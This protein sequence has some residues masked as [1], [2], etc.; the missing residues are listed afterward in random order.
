[1]VTEHEARALLARAA[2]TIE[3]GEDGPP[4]RD[5]PGRRPWG[6]EMHRVGVVAAVG[7]LV[8]GI[9]GA[10]FLVGREVG[11][12]QDGRGPAD[13]TAEGAPAEREHVYGADQMPSLIGYTRE[14]AV[15]LLR[16]EGMKVR[17]RPD[18]DGCNV[19]GIVTG[20]RTPVGS[21]LSPGEVVTIRVTEAAPVIDCV[22][23]AE[24]P[25]LWDVVRFARG[26]G[27]P[28]QVAETVQLSVERHGS[29]IAE[30]ERSG[31]Q[32]STPDGWALCGE[33]SCHSPLAGLEQMLT[34]PAVW[35]G[36]RLPFLNQSQGPLCLPGGSPAWHE[37]GWRYHLWVSTLVDGNSCP[38]MSLL[39]GVDDDGR[40]ERVGLR[41]PPDPPQELDEV[42]LE[43]SLDRTASATRFVTW[44]RGKSGPPDF[45]PRVRF[46]VDGEAPFGAPTWVADPTDPEQWAAC[47]GLPAGRCGLDP[48]WVLDHHD[49]RVAQTPTR[50]TCPDGGAVPAEL[51]EAVA[52]DLVRL[53]QP[54]PASCAEAWAVELWIDGQGRIYAVNLAVAAP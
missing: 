12:G 35:E 48:R 45:A 54:E 13:V 34:D 3:V 37:G 23:E 16:S 49:G 51:T 1:M 6:V 15:A 46:L 38:S 42:E 20:S 50:A 29:P 43:Q 36:G 26:L 39:L 22:G 33:E 9:A 31:A 8:A 27:D 25:L 32:L 17:V 52:T 11:G 14:E 19:P 21:T 53:D 41:L 47:S 28:P 4:R 5:G 2:G 10:G 40:L 7:V 24:W 44:S 30:T 18:R